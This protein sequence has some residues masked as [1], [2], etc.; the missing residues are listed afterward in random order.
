MPPQRLRRNARADR[1]GIALALGAILASF[2]PLGAGRALAVPVTTPTPGPAATL[3]PPSASIHAHEL[4]FNSPLVFVLEGA[5]SS[6]GSQPGQRIPVRL[7]DPIVIGGHTLAP[8][9]TPGIVRILAANSA[10][11][12]DVYGYVDVYF[13]PIQ[14]ANGGQLPLR[15]ATTRLSV[16]LTAGH[17]STVGI[18]DGIEDQ[19][20]PFHYIYHVFRKGQNFELGPGA[21]LQARTQAIVSLGSNGLPVISTPAPIAIGIHVPVSSFSAAPMATPASSKER[22]PILRPTM[23]PGYPPDAPSPGIR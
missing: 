6:N 10:Q 4:P 12:G 21:E 5:I 20:I 17:A 18:E 22:G 11:I 9:G 23:G 15:S 13:E 8:A 19:V 14:L 16:R 2:G 3:A 1:F 7:R